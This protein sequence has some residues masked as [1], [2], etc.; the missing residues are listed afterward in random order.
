MSNCPESLAYWREHGTKETIDHIMAGDDLAA[1]LKELNGLGIDLW[2]DAQDHASALTLFEHVMSFHDQPIPAEAKLWCKAASFNAGANLWRGWSDA[3]EISDADALRG[4]EFARLNLTLAYELKRGEIAIARAEWL[5]AAHQMQ[6]GQWSSA[7][8]G[9]ERSAG[10][11]LKANEL[12]EERMSHAYALLAKQLQAGQV[13]EAALR[14]CF[15]PEDDAFFSDQ[16]L[17]AA[18]A[19]S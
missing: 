17:D 16:V 1:N 8:A 5:L 9:F 11:A 15:L 12:A 13:D 4:M 3:P 2:R 19:F 7:I 6:Q 14:A 10:L 18:K